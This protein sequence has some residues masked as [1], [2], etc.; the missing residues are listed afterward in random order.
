VIRASSTPRILA[1]PNSHRNPHGWTPIEILNDAAPVGSAAHELCAMKARGTDVDRERIAEVSAKWACDEKTVRIAYYGIHGSDGRYSE[2]E[3]YLAVP[4]V[5]KFV[6]ERLEYEYLGVHFTGTPDQQIVTEPSPVSEMRICHTV[7]FKFSEISREKLQ[8]LYTY[9]FERFLV[10]EKI[11]QF[12]FW[13]FS[14]MEKERL[15]V[16]LSR[17]ELKKRMDAFVDNLDIDHWAVGTHC[18]YC[19][20]LLSCVPYKKFLEHGRR[21][22]HDGL[23]LDR[24]ERKV[25]R[26]HLN[27]LDKTDRQVVKEFGRTADGYELVTYT[28]KRYIDITDPETWNYITEH[29]I[30]PYSSIRKVTVS[31]LDLTASQRE[32]L[33]PYIRTEEGE[34]LK[35]VE[36]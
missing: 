30:D 9:A 29:N 14:M 22:V 2:L 15:F 18:H 27:M 1:C 32:G 36:G 16:V 4:I 17:E 33:E 35:K 26:D 21:K 12:W 8:Q 7:D 3:R 31:S 19:P 11:E 10:D 20:F 24:D 13:M 25:I 23:A 28:Q 5:E 34:R 6:E